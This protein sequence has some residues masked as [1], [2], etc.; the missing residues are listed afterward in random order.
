M[1]NEVLIFGLVNRLRVC[2][3]FVIVLDVGNID[4]DGRFVITTQAA[5]N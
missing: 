2:T 5:H 4:A 3:E 1:V